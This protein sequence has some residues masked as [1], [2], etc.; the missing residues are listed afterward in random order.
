MIWSSTE[1]P[2]RVFKIDNV[3]QDE[4]Q[5]NADTQRE[6]LRDDDATPQVKEDVKPA[7]P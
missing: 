4:S 5:A 3:D 1:A 2:D 7:E 6:S